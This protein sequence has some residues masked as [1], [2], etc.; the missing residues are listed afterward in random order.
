MLVITQLHAEG[1]AGEA[2]TF[3]KNRVD[4]VVAADATEVTVPFSFTNQ[5]AKPITIARVDSVCSCLYS[6]VKD[7]KMTYQPGEKGIIELRFELGKFSGEVNK[8]MLL[9]TT[10]D[11]PKTPSTT[12]D[13]Y[14]TIPELFKIEP[15]TTFWDRNEAL[16]TKTVKL[17]VSDQTPIHIKHHSGTSAN[18]TYQLR[19]I[20]EGWEYEMKITPKSTSQAGFGIFKLKT[21]SAISRY[22]TMLLY[23]SVRR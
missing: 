14:V 6:K 17:T 12:L 15:V 2:L 13:I 16:S 3:E 18:F 1:R 7:Q 19:T 5:T 23:G 21:D 11:D 8:S 10:D 22:Q 20:R 4:I 9:W